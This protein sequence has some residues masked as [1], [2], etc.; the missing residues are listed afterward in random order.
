MDLQNQAFLRLAHFIKQQSACIE[1][2]LTENKTF[3]KKITATQNAGRD[4]REN[5]KPVNN[6]AKSDEMDNYQ[7][8]YFLDDL[9]D[10]SVVIMIDLRTA[11]YGYTPFTCLHLHV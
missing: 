3:Y 10:N 6:E 11:G 4:K 5:G 1:S 2:Q 8:M 9:K 7:E